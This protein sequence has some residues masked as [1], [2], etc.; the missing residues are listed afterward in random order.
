MGSGGGGRSDLASRRG[1]IPEL[2]PENLRAEVVTPVL[3][4]ADLPRLQD[5]V[6]AIRA[7]GAVSNR[8]CAVH[9]H[10]DASPF[11]AV[12]LCNL[13]KLVYKQEPLIIRALG[14]QESRLAR[15]TKPIS[16]EFIAKIERS[17][18]RTREALNRAWYGYFNRAPDRYHSS[19]YSILN[20]NSV[21]YRGTLEIRA[22]EGTLHAGKIKA[23][24]Q[25]ALALAA[26]GLSTRAASSRKRTFDPA[27]AKYDLRI[28]LVRIGLVGDEFKTARKHLLGLLPGDAAFKRGRPPKKREIKGPASDLDALGVS[29]PQLSSIPSTFPEEPC[30]SSPSAPAGPVGAGPVAVPHAVLE[31]LEAVRRSGLTNMFDRPRVAEL[32]ESFGFEEAASWVEANRA[33]FAQGIFQGF[34]ARGEGGN[35]PEAGSGP[36]E[37]E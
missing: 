15:F 28:F 21:F 1:C 5:V 10:V 33:A 37:E 8:Q 22:F 11:S 31:G 32:A 2:V 14:V 7:T 16:P 34:V 20:F 4:Y 19:R 27:S 23:W 25:F 30:E 3:E 12:Q 18:P 29:A 24:V 6:R 35:P 9:L 36:G 17:R 13:A 26:R